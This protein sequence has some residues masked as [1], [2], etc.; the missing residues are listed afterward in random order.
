M[1]PPADGKGYAR[2]PGLWSD[3]QVQAWKPIV[4]A[5]T[6]IVAPSAVALAD[7]GLVYLHIVDHAAMGLPVVPTPFKQALRKAWPRTFFTPGAK[8]YTDYPLA[9]ASGLFAFQHRPTG[10]PVDLVVLV[11][12]NGAAALAA[13][14]GDGD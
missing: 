5:D 8:G 14:L 10:V 6:R 13:V 11:L 7:A 3:E 1:R 12:P 2:I 9:T 4:A